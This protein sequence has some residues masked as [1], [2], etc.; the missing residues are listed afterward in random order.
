MKNLLFNTWNAQ[1]NQLPVNGSIYPCA[2]DAA[3]LTPTTLNISIK[4]S[5]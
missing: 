4:T 5:V 2:F 1:L 3:V